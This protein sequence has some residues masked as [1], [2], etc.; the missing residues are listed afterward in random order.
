MS[1]PGHEFCTD[2]DCACVRADAREH[3]LLEWGEAWRKIALMG[4]GWLNS[5]Q[6]AQLPSH[7]PPGYPGRNADE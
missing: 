1:L 3:E 7:N 4:L 6:L 5:E 2:P